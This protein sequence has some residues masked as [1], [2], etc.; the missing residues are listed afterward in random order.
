M[1]RRLEDYSILWLRIQEKMFQ[2]WVYWVQRFCDFVLS[3]VDAI[4]ALYG[5]STQQGQDLVHRSSDRPGHASTRNRTWG[6]KHN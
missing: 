4:L 2:S 1:S 5:Q 6:R 3:G